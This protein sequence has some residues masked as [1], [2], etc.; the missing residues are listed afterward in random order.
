MEGLLAGMIRCI[1]LLPDGHFRWI[2]LRMNEHRIDGDKIGVY[3]SILH[4][5]FD[6][7]HDHNVA[8]QSNLE[9][10]LEQLIHQKQH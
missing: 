9:P 7:Q 4:Q 2:G 10:L 3:S 5:P 6:I 8:A 1:T